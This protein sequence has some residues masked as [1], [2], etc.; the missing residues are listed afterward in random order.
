MAKK[1][2]VN[3]D[4]KPPKA[5]ILL[6]SSTVAYSLAFKIN[7]K[8]RVELKNKKSFEVFNKETEEIIEFPFFMCDLEQYESPI[9]LIQNKL[10]EHLIV[11]KL[12]NIDYFFIIRDDV[13]DNFVKTVVENLRQTDSITFVSALNYE[14][15][16][17]FNKEMKSF[18]TEF[19]IHVAE[20]EK[21]EEESMF[22]KFIKPE[23]K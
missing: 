20:I 18:L 7:E 22:P 17:S 16:N 13:P 14:D 1:K 10:R 11:P 4:I 12:K 23:F 15:K 2:L 6:C 5:L 9:C 21:I 3:Q 8:L 19:E